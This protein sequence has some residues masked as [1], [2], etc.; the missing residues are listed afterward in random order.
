[1]TGKDQAQVDFG[2]RTEADLY[3]WIMDHQHYLRE[4]FGSGVGTEQAAAHFADHYTTRP[5]KRAIHAA[6]D[7]VAGP[8]EEF[9][10]DDGD[11]S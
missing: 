5:I 1:M 4:Q 8:E 2:V 10:T 3:L 9:I 6:R 11:E 7:L